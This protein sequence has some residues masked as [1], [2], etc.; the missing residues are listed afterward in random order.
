MNNLRNFP[1]SSLG[2]VNKNVEGGA[3]LELSRRG[4]SLRGP[5]TVSS[6]SRSSRRSSSLPVV[7]Q[8]SGRRY[9]TVVSGSFRVYAHQ[10]PNKGRRQGLEAS[11]LN[12]QSHKRSR[13]KVPPDGEAGVCPHV[14]ACFHGYEMLP[15]ATVV[16]WIEK[17][18][19]RTKEVMN[20]NA[21]KSEE[22]SALPWYHDLGL[23]M[24][25]DLTQRS[26]GS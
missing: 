20:N 23:I 11:I 19:F 24:D 6:R 12:Q 14:A 10:Y 5:W 8:T 2:N 16:E 9:P 26:S 4:R 21:S 15:E 3:F 7:G 13:S 1:T 17:E 18:A 25:R 22:S